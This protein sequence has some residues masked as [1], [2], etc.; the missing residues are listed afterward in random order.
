[1]KF[2]LSPEDEEQIRATFEAR[3]QEYF[4][5]LLRKWPAGDFIE[6]EVKR[7]W[8]PIAVDVV[9]EVIRDL[10]A[11]RQMVK[12]ELVAKLRRDAVAAMKKADALAEKQA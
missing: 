10:P 2:E 1:M 11:L 12:D 9:A 7:Q 8:Q 3:A 6:A 4:E 5:S